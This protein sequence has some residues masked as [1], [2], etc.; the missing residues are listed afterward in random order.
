MKLRLFTSIFLLSIALTSKI[1]AQEDQ[2]RLLIPIGGDP[3]ITE[4]SAAAV[5][6]AWR[7][8][9][10]ILVLPFA[11]ASDPEI[12]TE[13]ERTDILKMTETQRLEIQQSCQQ[14][15]DP[16]I[17]CE[18]LLAPI[19]V[20]A[21]A[22]DPQS[23]EYFTPNLTAI[24]ILGDD[25]TITTRALKDTLMKFALEQAYQNG[26][27]IAGNGAGMMLLSQTIVSDYY[28]NFKAAD[29]M[30]FG[31]VEV[32]TGLSFGI[33][34]VILDQQIM[35]ESRISRL[36][37]VIAMP[38]KPHVG[39]GVTA[40]T[41]F[42]ITNEKRVENIF[43]LSS[44]IV[45]D[46]ETYHS[47]DAVEYHLP[48]YLLSLRN[49]LV[50][51]LSPG[52]STYDI[53]ARQHSLGAPASFIERSFESLA[54]PASAGPLTL[55][56]DLGQSISNDST[57]TRFINICGGENAKILTIA[58]GYSSQ[59][60]AQQ[61]LDAYQA[62]V[63]IPIETLPIP[64]SPSEPLEIPHGITGIILIG[65]N[66]SLIQPEYLEP[67]KQAWLSGTPLLTYGTATALV[68][69]YYS[70][71]NQD[72]GTEAATTAQQMRQPSGGNL[73]PGLALLNI[74]IE[75]ETMTENRWGSLF[76]LA[77]SHPNLIAL[78]L[79]NN[80]VLKITRD[81]ALVSGENVVFTLDFRNATLDSG[82]NQGFVIANG[83]FDAFAPG[84]LVRPENA[85][86]S[87]AP[88]HAATPNLTTPTLTSTITSTPLPTNTLKPA[89]L[90]KETNGPP[91]TRTASPHYHAACC[92]TTC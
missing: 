54:L 80:T 68:G 86:I 52:D 30:I 5:D 73:L 59:S 85:D 56:G 13:N 38:D 3:Q 27:I 55:S 79:N 8:K 18:V 29:G 62:G 7:G 49:V 32:Q 90:R 41:G 83:L 72:T 48:L 63:K 60:I 78:G 45:L 1:T 15:A 17:V 46:T 74:T 10:K 64:P 53:S 21:D 42:Y 82:T 24:Y 22:E 66:K 2:E 81:G 33:K 65:D 26:V 36:L 31:A 14:F 51:L 87:A 76:S 47:A 28:S 16:G 43:G 91:A 35:Q 71:L 89:P 12:I 44:V 92:S 75:T 20:H 6:H 77:Y 58:A 25:Q 19:L 4:F 84:D 34:N 9:V 50:H 67:I 61:V 88:I 70:P 39:I 40:D 57:M 37:N 11:Y 23:L 69:A